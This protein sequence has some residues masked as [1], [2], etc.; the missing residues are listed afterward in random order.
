M[1]DED[2]MDD[3]ES[4]LVYDGAEGG[5]VVARQHMDDPYLQVGHEGLG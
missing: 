5:D 1:Q 2:G 3:G 4:G